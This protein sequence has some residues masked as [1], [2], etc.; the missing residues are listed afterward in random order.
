MFNRAYSV[1][2]EW[3]KFLEFFIVLELYFD[4]DSKFCLFLLECLLAVFEVY[5]AGESGSADSE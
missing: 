5:V 2:H 4:F 3:V 1:I